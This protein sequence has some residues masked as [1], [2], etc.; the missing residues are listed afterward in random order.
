ER[1]GLRHE[2]VSDQLMTEQ[3]KRRLSAVVVELADKGGQHFLDRELAVVAREISS[4]A[5]VLAA[6]K[7]ENLDAG[8]PACLIRR[9]DVGI[10]DPGDVDV[11]VALHQRQG[12]DPISDQ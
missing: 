12:A 2:L 9:N 4:V 6:A 8:L 11:L 7:E 1:Q 3:N 10:D 5:P